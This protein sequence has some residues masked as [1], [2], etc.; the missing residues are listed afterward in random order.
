MNWLQWILVQ[1]NKSSLSNK[2]SIQ[3]FFLTVSQ[4][5]VK[6]KH[7]ITAKISGFRN[8]RANIASEGRDF[9]AWILL[10]PAVV[11]RRIKI[12]SLQSGCFQ[13][14]VFLRNENIFIQIL[15]SIWVQ[16]FMNLIT[17]LIKFNSIQVH[18]Q[19]NQTVRILRYKYFNLSAF[20]HR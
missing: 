19:V 2:S 10:C 15:N 20:F 7:F 13:K 4:C 18:Q 3:S 11:R 5:H 1:T 14:K 17:S 8:L 12:K 16:V 9:V 6:L